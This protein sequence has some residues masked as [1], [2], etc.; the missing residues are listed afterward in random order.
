MVPN[1]THTKEKKPQAKHGKDSEG[2]IHFRG[3]RETLLKGR[4][5]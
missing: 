2:G 5:V 3:S 4:N 1:V